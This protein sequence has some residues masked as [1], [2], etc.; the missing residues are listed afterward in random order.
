[1]RSLKDLDALSICLRKGIDCLTHIGML[2]ELN[3]QNTIKA[4]I[5]RVQFRNVSDGWRRQ[6]LRILDERN[7]YPHIDDLRR[8]LDKEVRDL[9]DPVYGIADVSSGTH[10]SFNT[11]ITGIPRD[12]GTSRFSGNFTTEQ[13]ERVSPSSAAIQSANASS[14]PAGS[15]SRSVPHS[16]T[17]SAAQ[18]PY[19]GNDTHKLLKC[20]QFHVLSVSDRNAFVKENRICMLCLNVGHFVRDCLSRYRCFNCQRRHSRSL[21][22]HGNGGNTVGDNNHDN[23]Q[24]IHQNEQVALSVSTSGVFMPLVRVLVNGV[25]CVALLDS[26]SSR[27]FLTQDMA[28]MLGLVGVDVSFNLSRLNSITQMHTKTATVQVQAANMAGNV[29]AC[30]VCFTD[31]IPTHVP[32]SLPGVYAHLEGLSLCQRAERIDLLIGQD[33]AELLMPLEVRSESD[34]APYAVRTTLGWTLHGSI[35]CQSPQPVMCMFTFSDMPEKVSQDDI[36]VIKHWDANT[37]TVDGHYEIPVPWSDSTFIPPETRYMAKVRH[38]ALGVRLNA[39]SEINVMCNKQPDNKT[40]DTMISSGYAEEVPH[41]DPPSDSSWYLPHH[42][43]YSPAKHAKVRVV[44]DCSVRSRG[45]SLNDRVYQGPKLTTL[46]NVVL[47]CIIYSCV[48]SGD[49]QAISNQVKPPVGDVDMMRFLWNGRAYRKTSQLFGDSWCATRAVYALRRV[50]Q[51]DP[52]HRSDDVI[53]AIRNGLYVAD[54]LLSYSC[55]DRALSVWK[56]VTESLATRGFNFTNF[57]TYHLMLL[58]SILDAARAKK[59]KIFPEQ[60]VTSSSIFDPF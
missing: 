31:Y 55:P 56:E 48:I 3:S 46:L 20:E 28:D 52:V 17:V 58:A 38:D 54:L 1:M 40:M 16:R 5:S 45:S 49:V 32:P 39:K 24:T 41:A 59:V 43:V 29:Y 4:V 53:S 44:V 26:G 11:L 35:A 13:H 37:K 9:S 6:A 25:L 19:C 18:C 50:T 2:S 51:Y 21:C 42:H 34:G 22:D 15:R 27:T 8:F 12:D 57:V 23:L 47:L 7:S 30:N 14:Q 33:H 10:A 60:S 36:H